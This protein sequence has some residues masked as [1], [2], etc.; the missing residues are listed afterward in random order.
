MCQSEWDRIPEPLSVVIAS[1]FAF[2]RW[3]TPQLLETCCSH[4]LMGEDKIGYQW[5]FE[6][7]SGWT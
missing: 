2:E 3:G 6:M 7:Y 1:Y 5:I 4:G